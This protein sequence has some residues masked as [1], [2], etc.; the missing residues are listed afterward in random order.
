MESES[1]NIVDKFN[2]S[3][4]PIIYTALIENNSNAKRIIRHSIVDLSVN[5]IYQLEFPPDYNG[6]KSR[7]PNY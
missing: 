6:W 3:D 5:K 7:C 2:Q 1:L 4:L